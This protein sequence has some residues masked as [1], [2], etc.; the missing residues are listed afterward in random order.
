MCVKT[1]TTLL[2]SKELFL[3][4]HQLFS[5]LICET[6]NTLTYYKPKSLTPTEIFNEL[7]PFLKTR[8]SYVL[9]TA[10]QEAN[11]FENEEDIVGFIVALLSTKIDKIHDNEINGVERYYCS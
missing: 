7:S 10:N 3:R 6:Y 11:L 4:K 5:L 8:V 1:R 2:N 9:K